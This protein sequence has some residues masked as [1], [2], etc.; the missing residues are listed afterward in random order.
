MCGCKHFKG[1]T[2]NE[3]IPVRASSDTSFRTV[4]LSA[5][6]FSSKLQLLVGNKLGSYHDVFCLCKAMVPLFIVL[7]FFFFFF[8][9]F[10]WLWTLSLVMVSCVVDVSKLVLNQ[11]LELLGWKK[12]PPN[13][14]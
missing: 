7:F 10:F 5:L 1:S 2:P 12:L 9:F 14:S 8:F 4:D 3:L 13:V 6:F 11:Q